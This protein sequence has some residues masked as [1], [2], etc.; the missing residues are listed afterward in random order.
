MTSVTQPSSWAELEPLL[1]DIFASVV[2]DIG[3]AVPPARISHTVHGAEEWLL[4]DTTDGLAG[5]Y[6]WDGSVAN[7]IILTVEFAVTAALNR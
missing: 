4:L 2:R 6:Q 5:E 7:A 3:V 1:V